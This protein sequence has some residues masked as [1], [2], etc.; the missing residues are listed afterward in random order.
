[1]TD[2][3][4]RDDQIDEDPDR[5]LARLTVSYAR[6]FERELALPGRTQPDTGFLAAAGIG[7]FLGAGRRGAS[8]GR[9]LH[10]R[11]HAESVGFP[12][13]GTAMTLDVTPDELVVHRA[14]FLRG[15]P[16]GRAGG[17]PLDRISQAAVTRGITTSRIVFVL[18]NAALITVEATSA[19]RA[20]RF[21][22][23]L[24]EARDAARR[25]PP[26]AS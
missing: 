21:V 22:A 5:V 10:W 13:A 12:I 24:L 3:D 8:T 2:S 18:S 7:A 15:R 25:R 6:R 4:E 19:R 17:V 11:R 26:R 14:S 1:M 16:I 23:T 9:Y 20:R